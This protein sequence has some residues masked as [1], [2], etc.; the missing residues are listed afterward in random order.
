MND[1]LSDLSTSFL[2]KKIA[3]FAYGE[4]EREKLIAIWNLLSEGTTKVCPD[5]LNTNLLEL[6]TMDKK[7][8]ADCGKEIG[9]RLE[10]GQKPLV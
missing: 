4:I 6:R 2:R 8:C 10:K 9:W 3:G 5:C 7:V 1:R